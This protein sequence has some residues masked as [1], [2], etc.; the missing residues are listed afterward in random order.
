MTQYAETRKWM[1]LAAR[2]EGMLEAH[3]L[4]KGGDGDEFDRLLWKMT[5]E[6]IRDAS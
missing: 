5:D 4:L 3:K 6:M 1:L 2:L